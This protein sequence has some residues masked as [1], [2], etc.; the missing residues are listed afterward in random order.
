[1]K[2]SVKM[3]AIV[4]SALAAISTGVMFATAVNASAVH[5]TPAAVTAETTIRRSDLTRRTWT[6]DSITDAQG[7]T[8]DPY[9]LFGSSFRLAHELVLR[10]DGTFAVY[11]GANTGTDPC[12]TFTYHPASAKLTMRYEDGFRAVAYVAYKA[13]GDTI[14]K[15]PVNLYGE[16]YVIDF[17]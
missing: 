10:E 6:V 11:L 13:N 5:T 9:R 8:I 7:N 14:L 15:V 16:V 17:A 12:G 3:F 4:L 1:M 2:K